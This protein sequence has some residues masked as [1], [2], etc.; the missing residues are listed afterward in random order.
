MLENGDSLFSM[1]SHQTNLECG[2][3]VE[4]T[5]HNDARIPFPGW[6][7]DCEHNWDKRRG[8]H[9]EEGRV[10]LERDAS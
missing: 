9:S 6:D 10:T 5:A 8:E 7:H 3:I 1:T 4:E 2:Y